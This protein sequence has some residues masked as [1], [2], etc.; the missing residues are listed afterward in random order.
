MNLQ[1]L[2]SWTP[3]ERACGE[4]GGHVYEVQIREGGP[5]VKVTAYIFRSWSGARKLD[6]EPFTG[7]VYILGSHA[8]ARI[9]DAERRARL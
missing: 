9:Q 6:G 1:H 5:F 3:D 7:P 8:D 2:H 4:C